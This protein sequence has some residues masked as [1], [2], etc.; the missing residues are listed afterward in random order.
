VFY[1]P[2]AILDH[3]LLNSIFIRMPKKC[4]P[5]DV[6]T[7]L[8][9]PLEER[10]VYRDLYALESEKLFYLFLAGFRHF[11]I[12]ALFLNITLRL[13]SPR[14]A[15]ELDYSRLFLL[16]T[17]IV[18]HLHHNPRLLSR[19]SDSMANEDRINAYLQTQSTSDLREIARHL[20]QQD[21]VAKSQL[22]DEV[23][24]TA[25]TEHQARMRDNGATQAE[26]MRIPEASKINQ[27]NNVF[28]AFNI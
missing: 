21:V 10:I 26:M 9:H 15:P 11:L 13:S 5:C 25:M 2:E 3:Q 4:R 18:D 17:L 24:E 6:L 20:R 7:L 19:S 22:R 27:P 14:V 1:Q 12:P 8:R 16:G 23:L 28:D